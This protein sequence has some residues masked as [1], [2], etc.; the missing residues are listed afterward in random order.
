MQLHKTEEMTPAHLG[1]PDIE[2]QATKLRKLRFLLLILAV[3]ATACAYF[4]GGLMRPEDLRWEAM[5]PI[6]SAVVV[7][8]CF[9]VSIIIAWRAETS[10]RNTLRINEALNQEIDTRCGKA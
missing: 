10:C 3:P 6:G 7:F 8:I 2:T 9:L 5:L 1:I 4:L